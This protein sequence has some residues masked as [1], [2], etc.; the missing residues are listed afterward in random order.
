MN[1]Y[2]D[3][4]SC[5]YKCRCYTDIHT[6]ALVADCS[7]LAQREIP[8]N[9]PNYTDWLLISGN[10]I[11]T[12]NEDILQ[13]SFLAHITKL[14]LSGNSFDNISHEFFD[15]FTNCGSRLSFLNI[16]NNNLT[17]LPSTIQNISS[18]KSLQLT[19]NSFQC[20]CE[21]IWM[22]DWLNK[23]DII[24]DSTNI[25]CT[26]PSGKEIPMIDM[27][28]KDMD[29]PEPESTT[30]ANLWKI[31]GMIL[32]FLYYYIILLLCF[33]IFS[34]FIFFTLKIHLVLLL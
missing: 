10:H 16:S 14:D 18:L 20:N 24:D 27:N 9:L 32:L 3:E 6:R 19:G 26:M 13:S 4:F 25:T 21:N 7:N 17:M 8:L 34:T 29:C 28:P 2:S 31:L 15:L 22:G 33:A 12:F 5:G 11:S 1:I 30:T 23:I